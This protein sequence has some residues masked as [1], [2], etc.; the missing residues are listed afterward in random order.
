M[1]QKTILFGASQL[2]KLAFDYLKNKYDIV[3]YC[4]N[5][6]NKV[7]NQFNGLEIID[8]QKLEKLVMIKNYFIIISSYYYKEIGEQ[9]ISLGINHDKFKVFYNSLEYLYALENMES[10]KEDLKSIIEYDKLKYNKKIFRDYNVHL[11]FDNVYT[12]TYI[13]EI[14]MK[15]NNSNKNIFIINTAGGALKFTNDILTCKNV[16]TLDFRD[17]SSY[18]KLYTYIVGCKKLFIHFLSDDICEILDKF[19]ISN[20][21]CEKYWVLWGADIYNYIDFK[22]YEEKTYEFIKN[23]KYYIGNEKRCKDIEKTAKRKTIIENID[24]IYAFNEGDY[25]LVTLNYATNAKYK[26]FMY[27]PNIDF[28]KLEQIRSSNNNDFREKYGFK[29]LILV[30]NSS[31]W[32]NNHLDVFWKIKNL[33]IT[34]LGVILPLSYG[35]K[36]YAEEITNIGKEILGDRIIILD[37]FLDADEYY[38]IINQV[39]VVIMNHRRQQAGGNIIGALYLGKKLFMNRASTLYQTL[40]A[41]GLDVCTIEEFDNSV[42]T[43]KET[44]D[45]DFRR[46]VIGELWNNNNYSKTL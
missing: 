21:S 30:G 42:F 24:Y 29:Y 25:R 44:I 37:S 40:V 38:N 3:Y 43:T 23:K 45:I 4:D 32:S 9:L 28:S 14:N 35:N 39:D 1:N 27:N 11:M 12:K 31:T 2:G 18:S 33:G 36:E 19:D 16:E 10:K 41:E 6:K 46:K 20:L 13:N 26:K 8:V 17:F 15:K 7:G 5:D 34:S 22:M